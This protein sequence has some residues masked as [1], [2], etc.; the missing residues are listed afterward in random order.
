METTMNY[1]PDFGCRYFQGT[2][3]Q[4]RKTSKCKRKVKSLKRRKKIILYSGEPK[5]IEGHILVIICE[6]IFQPGTM[7]FV[8]GFDLRLPNNFMEPMLRELS[9]MRIVQIYIELQKLEC[10]W[11]GIIIISKTWWLPPRGISGLAVGHG[12]WLGWLERILS[13]F[14]KTL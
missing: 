7:R 9:P 2:V 13:P 4:K 12:I 5:K 10:S 11:Q 14:Y 1:L 6:S 3:S 8:V